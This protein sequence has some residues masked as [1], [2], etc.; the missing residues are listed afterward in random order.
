MKNFCQGIPRRAAVRIKTYPPVPLVVAVFKQ[1]STI[2]LKR[3]MMASKDGKEKAQQFT[4]KTPKGTKGMI[5]QLS[6]IN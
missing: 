5:Y 4:L 2:T 3:E 6:Y 1:F